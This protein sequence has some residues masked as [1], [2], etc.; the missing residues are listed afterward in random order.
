M[1]NVNH[2]NHYTTG[3]IECIDAIKA[4]LGKPGFADFCRGNIIKYLWR[5]RLKNGVEDLKKAR[6]YLEWMIEAEDAGMGLTDVRRGST[7]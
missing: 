7:G 6:A 2:P 3:C 4:S 5:Y 1:D